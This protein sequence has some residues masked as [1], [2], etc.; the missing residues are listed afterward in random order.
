MI[1]QLAVCVAR[2]V[3]IVQRMKALPHAFDYVHAFSENDTTEI[4]PAFPDAAHPRTR[5]TVSNECE[6]D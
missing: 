3:E 5:D 1:R 6:G 2:F 4:Y